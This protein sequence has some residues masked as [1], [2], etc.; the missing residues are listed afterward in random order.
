MKKL[1]SMV[2]AAAIAAAMAV[3]VFAAKSAFTDLDDARYDWAR[4]NIEKMAEKGYITGYDDGTFKP[5][6]DITKLECIA[7]F[8][9]AMGAKDTANSDILSKAHDTYDDMIKPYY[10]S[11]GQDEIVYMLYKGALTKSDLDTYIKDVKDEPM[12]RYEAAVIITK[13]MG[14][15]EEAKSEVAIDLEYIDVNDIPRNAMQYVNYVAKQGIMTGMDGNKFEPLS[16]VLRS[17]MATM[18]SRV[19]DKTAYEYAEGKLREVNT[20]S[21]TI[22][23]QTSTGTDNMYY[24]DDNTQF[25]IQG[26]ATSAAD[27]LVDVNVNITL[28]NGM[29]VIVDATSSQPDEKV[30]GR[31]QGNALV[32]NNTIIKL[33]PTGE[34]KVKEYTCSKD[35]TVTY[36]G[37]P[38]T[39]RSFAIDDLMTIELEDGKVVS[40]T[41]QQKTQKI[42]NAKLVKVNLDDELSMTISHANEE[43]NNMTYPVSDSVV[44]IK[45]ALTSDMSSL[46][47]GDSVDLT[48]EYG[49]VTRISATSATRAYEGTIQSI[50]IA[51]EASMVVR[52]NGEDKTFVVPAGVSITIN[53]QEGSLYDFRVGDFVTI[54]TES[55]AITKIVSSGAAVVDGKISGVV[56]SVN[57]SFGFIKIMK[58]GADVAETVFC[59]NAT[60]TVV[61]SKGVTKSVSDIKVGDTVDTRCTVS[62]GAYTAKLIIIEEQ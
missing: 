37:S 38:A 16:P 45:N 5:D 26:I 46:Y 8:A 61:T 18:L 4:D 20:A 7:L 2:T 50:N 53:G 60:V 34:K 47:P 15:E 23:V 42:S 40:V 9:R 28:S 48:L 3:P 12:K 30:T 57:S 62:N 52:V 11:W 44:V 35:L 36:E 6:Q 14:G 43:Y 22:T 49:E 13:A 51:T 56:T 1:I 32:S 31:Y 41:G 39:L 58:D 17:Q 54:T 55:G 33:L 29:A 10:L 21:K 25:K 59:K 24:Y 19:V 27:M